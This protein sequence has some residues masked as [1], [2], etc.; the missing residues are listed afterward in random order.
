MSQEK[1]TTVIDNLWN[2][3]TRKF[4]RPSPEEQRVGIVLLRE[5]TQRGP[6]TINQLAETLGVSLSDT[7]SFLD[8]SE[9]GR[10]VIRDKD[11]PDRIISFWGLATI[12]THHKLT[13]NGQTVWAWCAGDSLFLPELLGES[14]RI[15]ST[16]PEGDELVELTVSPSG[17]ESVSHDNVFVSMNSPEVW[18]TSSAESTIKS[19]CHYIFFFASRESGERWVTAHPETILLPLAATF[20]LVQRW[21]EWVFGNELGTKSD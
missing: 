3:M 13:M 2:G 17:I 11:D 16:D 20:E 19:A 9:L 1:N 15:E 21:N 10:M 12:P 4:S 18:D 7:I 5:L 14:A 8:E 6:V